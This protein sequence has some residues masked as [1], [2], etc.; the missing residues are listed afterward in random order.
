MLDTSVTKVIVETLDP[1]V[2]KDRRELMERLGRLDR[3]EERV[4]SWVRWSSCISSLYSLRG[5]LRYLATLWW[6]LIETWKGW[7]I[8]RV[9]MLR[10]PKILKTFSMVSPSEE[11]KQGVSA[12]SSINLG[13]TLLQITRQ[14]KTAKT[15]FLARLSI[16]QSSIV[17]QI[18]DFNHWMVTIFSFDHM[19]GENREFLTMS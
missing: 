13:D 10:V 8:F 11:H 12:Q 19:T 18:L 9:L 4:P 6:K 14:W 2:Q 5:Q 3:L 16:Y 15:W 7:P 17:S 1:W